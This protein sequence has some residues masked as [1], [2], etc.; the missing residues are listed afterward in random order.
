[1]REKE[2]VGQAGG[3]GPLPGVKRGDR[4]TNSFVFFDFLIRA[5]RRSDVLKCIFPPTGLDAD[6]VMSLRFTPA[7][8]A[9]AWTTT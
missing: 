5:L 4:D 3:E 7:A 1:M 2:G 9:D 8:S 6:W